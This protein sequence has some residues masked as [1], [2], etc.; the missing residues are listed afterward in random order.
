MVD[1]H[2]LE[3]E[4]DFIGVIAHHS[5]EK[6]F[7]EKAKVYFYDNYKEIDVKLKSG[8]VSH[9][10]LDL[11]Q[12]NKDNESDFVSNLKKLKLYASGEPR[13]YIDNTFQILKS[14]N[15]ILNV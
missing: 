1:A 5:I 6:Y 9:R 12:G 8:K 15:S 7:E 3:H 10:T 14:M 4:M 11:Y 13:K 2:L